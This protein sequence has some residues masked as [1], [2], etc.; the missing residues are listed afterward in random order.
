MHLNLAGAH[1]ETHVSRR[2]SFKNG[3]IPGAEE[4]VSGA[5]TH[6]CCLSHRQG[7]VLTSAGVEMLI[8]SAKQAM[9]RMGQQ[10]AGGDLEQRWEVHEVF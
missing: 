8:P 4:H 2:V 10:R 1:L 7:H 3:L 5:E 9:E 6:S